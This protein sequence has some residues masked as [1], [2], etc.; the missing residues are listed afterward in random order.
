MT[1]GAEHLAGTNP[2]S[3]SSVFKINQISSGGGGMTVTWTAVPGKSYIV[4]RSFTLANGSW[5][6]VSGTLTSGTFTDT[7]PGTGNVFY[8]VKIAP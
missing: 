6:P 4:E 2:L 8:R 7:N 3:A 1:N 5:S